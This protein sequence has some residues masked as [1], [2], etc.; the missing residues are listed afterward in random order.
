MEAIVIQDKTVRLDV[1]EYRVGQIL[2]DNEIARAVSD[3]VAIL[4]FEEPASREYVPNEGYWQRF[5]GHGRIVQGEDVFAGALW[6]K[7]NTAC[8]YWAAKVCTKSS[9]FRAQLYGGPSVGGSGLR[10]NAV[11]NVPNDDDAKFEGIVYGSSVVRHIPGACMLNL[12][13]RTRSHF[14]LFEWIAITAATY[15]KPVH[16]L[17]GVVW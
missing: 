9:D 10:P 15:E 13:L 3:G 7:A 6:V 14:A 1:S 4:P 8:V 5:Y 16:P 12:D 11:T 2:R 17:R